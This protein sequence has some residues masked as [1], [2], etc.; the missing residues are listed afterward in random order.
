LL[1]NNG[2]LKSEYRFAALLLVLTLTVSFDVPASAATS[3]ELKK[4]QQNTQQQLNQAS[5]NVSSLEGK[6]EEISDELETASAALAQNI[7]SVQMIESQISDIEAQIEVKQKEYDA[8]EATRQQQYDSMKKRIQYMYEKGN[9]SYVQILMKA[10]SFGDALNK[11][12]YVEELYDY[13]RKMLKEYETTVQEVAQAKSDLEDD[14]ADEEASKEALQEEQDSLQ[15]KQNELQAKYDNYD[16]LIASAQEKA[17]ELQAQYQRDT[18]AYNTQAQAEAKAAEEERKRAAEAA[19]AAAAAAAQA[20]GTAASSESS[21]SGTSSESSSTGT[22]K[23]Y[24]SAGSASGQNVVN[25]ACQFVG[26]PYVY[27][28]TSLTGG[29]DCSG[30]TMSVYRAFGYSLPRTAEAQRGAGVAVDS[31][32]DAQPG[33][34]ICYAGHVALY[35]GNGT[36]VHASTART[37]IKYS[38][39]TY[40][41]IICIRRIIN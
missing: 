2:H 12:E 5:G 36:I 23:T 14:K 24:Q 18:E 25:Y 7:A 22:S 31:L 9:L 38:V 40:R 4:Q 32:A 20:A 37:G 28:G 13:D 15:A 34:L 39:A 6:Q 26:N 35:C 21:S 33:D 1:F 17:N 3:S 11:A 30:F 19:A 41:D 16:S 27:G 10:S 29:T 8:A